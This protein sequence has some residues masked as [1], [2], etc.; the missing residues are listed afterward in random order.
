MPSIKRDYVVVVML[1]FSITTVS[2]LVYFKHQENSIK[3]EYKNALVVNTL[4]NYR[5]F[6][7]KH[8]NTKYGVDIIYYRD[9]KAFEN[10]KEIDS[11]ESYQG[12][13]DKYP[14][15]AWYS[16]VVYHRDRT[17]LEMAKEDR[18]LESIVQFLNKFPNSSWLPQANYYLRHQFGFKSLSEAEHYLP[19]YN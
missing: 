6:T 9:K 15:S 7:E 18:T 19:N 14:K 4:Q 16:N 12:F 11:F 10:A 8:K 13:L 5:S 3:V 2:Y 17:A 1:L